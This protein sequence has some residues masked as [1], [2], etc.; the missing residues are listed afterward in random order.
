M[1]K[2]I[3][4]GLVGCSLIFGGCQSTTNID[5]TPNQVEE[6]ET[7]KVY[8]K[9]TNQDEYL[10]I[11]SKYKVEPVYYF[12]DDYGSLFEELT[13]YY[14]NEKNSEYDIE[15]FKEEFFID[16][17]TII[18]DVDINNDGEK[19]IVFASLGR[20]TGHFSGI[21]YIF[22][23]VN[24]DDKEKLK[25]ID[26]PNLIFGEE[27]IGSFI[28]ILNVEGEY[29]V[30]LTDFSNIDTL[31]MWKDDAKVVFSEESFVNNDHLDMSNIEEDQRIKDEY[32]ISEV[33]S[34][35]QEKN[36]DYSVSGYSNEEVL[37]SYYK[38]KDYIKND[39]KE[40]LSEMIVYPIVYFT[41]G[42]DQVKKIYSKE[43]FVKHYGDFVTDN[44]KDICETSTYDQLF[45]NWKGNMIGDGQIWFG[46]YILAINDF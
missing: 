44:L 40:K 30:K 1:K 35:L 25:E 45:S 5:K 28:D 31:Y 39:E 17:S 23:I 38:I 10:D 33:L 43:D 9:I 34:N 16:S 21:D 4:L 8:E 11:V 24:E 6:K 41:D 20:G 27:A 19:E 7:S 22:K 15:K 14:N 3:I 18:Y 36:I 32:S 26:V 46:K 29:I 12:E 42:S 2:A 37:I 13:M